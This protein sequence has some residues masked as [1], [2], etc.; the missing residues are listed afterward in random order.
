MIGMGQ[1]R[2]INTVPDA[3]SRKSS[4]QWNYSAIEV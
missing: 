2:L 3:S 4:N 1:R